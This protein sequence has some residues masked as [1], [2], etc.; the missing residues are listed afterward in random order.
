MKPG[1][2]KEGTD[3]P[4]QPYLMPIELANSSLDA[5]GMKLSLAMPAQVRG[6]PARQ[7][8]AAAGAERRLPRRPAAGFR[9]CQAVDHRRG[10]G[11]GRGGGI[12]PADI[13]G[14]QLVFVGHGYVINKT[15]T[16]PYQ[17]IDVR[18]KVMIVAGQ[19][20]EMVQAMQ[21]QQAAAAAARAGGAGAPAAGARGGGRG[22]PT[23]PLGVEGTDFTSPQNYAA[24]NG[25]LGI[26]MVP[27]FQQLSAMTTPAA[28]G[29]RGAGLNGPSFQVVK[30][31][32]AQQ[33]AVPSITAGLELTNALFQGEKLTAAQ[34]FEGATA[35]A[36]IESFELN[37][38][39]K[40]NLRIAVNTLKGHTENVVGIIEGSDP[41]LKNEYVVFSA[42]LD[43]V[44]GLSP[45]AAVG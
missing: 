36:R 23:N 40:L 21:A 18:G 35:N 5:A 43:H 33:A 15:N 25:A 12:A 3:G 6:D 44:G 41:V 39:K 14:A 11:G 32:A 37:S 38:E 28:G 19:P 45:A 42:H 9:L 30:F 27:T 4:L 24:K 22:G 34:V 10:G 29:G 1:G 7:R 20:A 26:I 16:N 13:T 8:R 2:S 31:Q 17:G